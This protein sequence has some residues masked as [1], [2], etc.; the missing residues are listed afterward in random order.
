MDNAKRAELW[1]ELR[2]LQPII[3]KFDGFAFKIKS[4]FITTIVAIAGIAIAKIQ[5]YQNYYG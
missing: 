1:D 2:L 5:N 3:D 4:W